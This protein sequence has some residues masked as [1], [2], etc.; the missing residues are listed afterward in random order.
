V[1]VLEQIP[2]LESPHINVLAQLRWEHIR[3]QIPLQLRHGS[4]NLQFPQSPHSEHSH[5]SG[6][7]GTFTVTDTLKDTPFGFA[8][9]INATLPVTVKVWH[10]TVTGL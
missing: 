7:Q 5:P 8:T 3:R 6:L 9:P 2:Q 10:F 4:Q 1:L